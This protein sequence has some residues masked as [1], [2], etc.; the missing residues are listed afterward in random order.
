[1][2]FKYTWVASH[3]SMNGEPKF[4]S[5]SQS[6]IRRLHLLFVLRVVC[7]GKERLSY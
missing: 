1:M 5:D 7:I 6:K 4:L 3:V 2:H